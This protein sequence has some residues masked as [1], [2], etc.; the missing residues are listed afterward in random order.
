MVP[1][2]AATIYDTPNSYNGNWSSSV[3]YNG[4][5]VTIGIAGDAA[6]TPQVVVNYRQRFLNGDTTAPTVSNNGAVLGGDSDEAYLDTEIAG[7]M[8]PGATIH[9][10]TA[11]S[12]QGG[13]QTAIENAIADPKID[14]LSVSFGLCEDF[15]SN[16]QNTTINGWWQQA[17]AAGIAVTVS[18]GDSG[19]AG[20]DN[21]N[22]VTTASYGLAVN[23][24]SS[25]P[26]NI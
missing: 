2:D 19:S 12:S 7:G 18:T 1:S 3:S 24:F 14:I 26:Y 25:T 4:T 21:P 22:N 23:G 11:G 17:S 20:C 5:G 10:Y 9:F 8:A 16:T 13:L 15:L 6:I